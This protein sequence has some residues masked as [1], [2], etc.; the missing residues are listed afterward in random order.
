MQRAV[1]R[2]HPPTT[3]KETTMPSSHASSRRKVGLAVAAG[4]TIAAALA[5]GSGSAPATAAP[6]AQ[7]NIVR[8]AASAG[9]F[10]TL[11]TLAKKAGLVGALSAPGPLTVFAPTDAA[12]KSVPKA[13]LAKLA[14]DKAAL[15][16]VLLYHVVQGNVTAARVVKLRS[17]TTL[18]GPSVAI[19]VNGGNVFLNG[20][21]KVVKT[22]IAASNGTIHVIN[23][24]LL[25][26][27]K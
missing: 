7:Q 20:S 14:N 9:Q 5:L 15:R 23:K 16:R 10:D 18:A 17:A 1:K 8:T 24:V 25:P 12:F 21:T 6:N 11:L 3:T 13:T 27:A 22:D 19:R 4:A 2:L 26:P